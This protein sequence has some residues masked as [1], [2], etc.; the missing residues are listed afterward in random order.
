MVVLGTD[1]G[2]GKT[3]TAAALAAVRL[4]AGG[5][6]RVLKPVQTGA[7]A[8]HDAGE[9]DQL[10]GAPVAS[11]GWRLV[12]A[13]APAVAARL[14]AT[15]LDFTALRAW[16][17]ECGAG[18]DHVFVETAGGC[19]VELCEGYD[20]SRLAADLGDPAVLVC[21]AGLG[22]LNHALL[23]VEHAQRAGV[24]LAGL[25]I[26]GFPRRPGLA[27]LTNPAELERL[28]GLPILGVIP[29]LPAPVRLADGAPRRWLSPALGGVF[30]REAFVTGCADRLRAKLGRRA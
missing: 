3:I 4:A 7:E 2:V 28:T 20:M 10:V 24:R 21:R 8:D 26:S 19:A 12:A 23:S 13:L 6:V 17:N 25:V 30:D 9:V 18:A 5:N 14:E 1:T 27:A 16:V 11:T 15:E 29:R 22:T